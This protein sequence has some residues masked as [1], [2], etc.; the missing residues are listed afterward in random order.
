MRIPGNGA[1]R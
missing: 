1:V